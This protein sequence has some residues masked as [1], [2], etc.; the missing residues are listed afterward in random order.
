MELFKKTKT[1]ESDLE[2]VFKDEIAQKKASRDMA[3]IEKFK[4]LQHQMLCIEA[5]RDRELA[6]L[7]AAR[8][9]ARDDE[10]RCRTELKVAADRR[11]AAELACLGKTLETR[12]GQ[13]L[14]YR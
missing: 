2:E 1:T 8:T 11:S 6:E 4:N 3:R 12:L 14:E 7:H 10:D 9:T 5:D 13:V